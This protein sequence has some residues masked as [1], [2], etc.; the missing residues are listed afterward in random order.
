MQ[1]CSFCISHTDSHQ[2]VLSQ[3]VSQSISAVEY[4]TKVPSLTIS[5]KGMLCLRSQEDFYTVDGHSNQ[6]KLQVS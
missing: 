2:L 5:T 6:Y 3:K 1:E 4:Q